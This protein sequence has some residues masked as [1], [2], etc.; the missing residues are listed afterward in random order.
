[1]ARR[2]EHFHTQIQ[3]T[4]RVESNHRPMIAVDARLGRWCR[5]P[6]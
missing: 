3:I 1:M 4:E 2:A 5:E 6:V